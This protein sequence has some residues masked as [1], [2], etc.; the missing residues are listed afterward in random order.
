MK[1]TN[2]ELNGLRIVNLPL[3]LSLNLKMG[4]KQ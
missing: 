3:E 2:L 1:T 4:P